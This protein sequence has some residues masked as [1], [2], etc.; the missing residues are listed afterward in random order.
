MYSP[1]II[2]ARLDRERARLRAALGDPK[3]EFVRHTPDWCQQ[4]RAYFNQAPVIARY[5]SNRL[6]AEE[7]RI[8]QNE[9]ALCRY[10]Y[11]YYLKCYYYLET[12]D[13]R[14][15]LL[16]PNPAQ[17]SQIHQKALLEEKG[18]GIEIQNNKARQVGITSETEADVNHRVT[19][20][21]NVNAV[22][23]SSNPKKSRAMS[24]KMSTAWD[25][26][27]IF[28]LPQKGRWNTSLMEFSA[29]NSGVEI[30]S[31]AQF[32][33][34][35]RGSTPTVYHCS[36]VSE[37][38]D[39]RAD[40]DNAM[41]RAIHTN[42]ETF[43][44][45]ES[46]ALMMNDWWHATW[47]QACA[48]ENRFTPRFY[49]WYLAPDFYP[50]PT[51]L[52]KFPIPGDWIPP[53]HVIK[54]AEKCRNYVMG[55]DVVRNIVG[56]NWK[57]TREQLW[58]YHREYKAA[59]ERHA[60]NDFLR[61][62]PGTADEAWQVTGYSIFDAEVLQSGYENCKQPVGVYGFRSHSDVIPLRLQA[63]E[64]EIDPQKPPIEIR[65]EWTPD[66]VI[67]ATLVPLKWRG[68]GSYED[69][70]GR[71]K[72]FIWEF[73]RVGHD[74]GISVDT[75]EGIG[76]NQSVLQGIRKQTASEF[77]EQVMEYASTWANP[78]DLINVGM[79]LGTLFSPPRA[80]GSNNQAKLIA[81]V[82]SESDITQF[83]MTKHG[84]YNFHR[85]VSIDQF[86]LGQATHNKKGWYTTPWS[87][88]R[89]MAWFIFCLK[90]GKF[91][92]NSPWLLNECKTLHKDMYEQALRAEAGAQDD[93]VMSYAFGWYAM[94]ELDDRDA[95]M[96]LMKMQE[97]VKFSG[98][99]SGQAV[100]FSNGN[101]QDVLESLG[102]GLGAGASLREFQPDPVYGD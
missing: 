47:K 5:E 79:I 32:N 95:E 77:S 59:K 94:H 4:V 57:F 37:W 14:L 89:I 7:V 17:R 50:T 96:R 45:L 92:L 24:D 52:L 31:G 51:D 20:Y 2:D 26:L 48:G 39:P 93:R 28:L 34:L 58:F 61:E 83:E 33:G 69:N 16:N 29:Q 90:S 84:W 60:L 42:P 62:M 25:N 70:E 87:R 27:P 75:S 22:V 71:D 56:E 88:K 10:D 99:P 73:P 86:N 19:F 1:K 15:V 6:N 54:Y 72:V 67:E 11:L 91:V 49:G 76:Q 8:V 74:Y 80:D 66:H 35:A 30:G 13:N 97:E 78:I 98:M 81:E 102:V 65:C 44:V 64:P 36:E 23:A 68:Y 40:I 38:N 46:T 43:G 82:K 101:A 3:F 63:P 12:A 41:L 85:Y 18:L 100:D 9:R 21:S 55:D 53:D